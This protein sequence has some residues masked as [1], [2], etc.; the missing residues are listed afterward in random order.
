MAAQESG[1]G[2]RTSPLSFCLARDGRLHVTSL[3]YGATGGATSTPNV[4][5]NYDAG[6]NRTAMYDGQGSVMYSYNNLAQLTS[7]T[8]S[9]SGLGYYSLSYGYNLAGELNSITNPFNAQVGYDYDKAG[10]L[11]NVNGSGYSTVSNYASGITY[12]A[13]GAIKGM[14]SGNGRTL[15]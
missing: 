1:D 9:F 7:E 3:T 14:R 11:T 13:F 4:Y 12:R 2:V 8:R 6:G 15:S 5:F 10:R